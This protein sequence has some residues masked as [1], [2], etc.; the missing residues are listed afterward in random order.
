MNVLGMSS[1]QFDSFCQWVYAKRKMFSCKEDFS[2]NRIVE[3]KDQTLSHSDTMV[4]EVDIKS[5]STMAKI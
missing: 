5:P 2:I 4:D 3:C 1:A